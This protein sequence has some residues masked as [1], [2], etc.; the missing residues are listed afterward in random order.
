VGEADVICLATSA[1]TP[2]VRAAD[3][4]PGAHVNA[5]GS[6]TPEMQEFEPAL[7]GRA[8]VVVDQRE[9]AM[10]EAGEVIAAVRAGLLSEGDLVELGEVV[11]EQ[12]VGRYS[13]IQLTLFKSV[14]IA[15]QDV[16]AATRA[17]EAVRHRAD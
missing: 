15:L 8:L 9:A 4:P 7:L 10:A 13:H 11:V 2:V 17:V 14:G 3:L 12:L 5:I 16:C 1:R 6:F